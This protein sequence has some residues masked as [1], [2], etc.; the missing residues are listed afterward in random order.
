MPAWTNRPGLHA[1]TI[2]ADPLGSASARL[3]AEGV[4]R[5]DRTK[6]LAFLG[7]LLD[8]TDGA[9]WVRIPVSVLAGEFAIEPSDA[10][11]RVALLAL[12]GA[13]EA[14]DDGWRI[15]GHEGYRSVGL[16]AADAMALI[17]EAIRRPPPDD[18]GELLR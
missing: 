4:D 11:E 13:V 10:V 6:A 8:P 17:A 14:G 18:A 2:E 16:R 7:L 12:A 15:V 9:G 1:T 5:D 3:L